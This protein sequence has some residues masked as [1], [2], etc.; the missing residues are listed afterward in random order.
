V[1]VLNTATVGPR[2]IN[3]VGTATPVDSTYGA[4]GA[5]VVDFPGTPPI[6][7]CPGPNYIVQGEL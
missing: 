3:I 4:G 6:G 1:R 7:D 2:T 5:F